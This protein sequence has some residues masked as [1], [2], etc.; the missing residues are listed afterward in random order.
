MILGFMNKDRITRLTLDFPSSSAGKESTCSAGD[1]SSFPGSGRSPGEGIGCPLQYSWASVAAQMV[2][3]HL[4]GRRPGFNSWVG[5]I[6]WRPAW[7]PTPVFLPRESPW[8]EE[9]GRLQSKPSQRVRHNWA[10]KHT[11]QSDLGETTSETKLLIKVGHSKSPN[12]YHS[13]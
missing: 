6:P 13:F 7:Q 2:K 10:T 5:K 4:Q 9:L 8:T 1:P 11:A 3:N 12:R